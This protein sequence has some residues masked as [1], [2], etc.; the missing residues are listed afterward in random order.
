[1][2]F[3]VSTVT[4]STYGGKT[5]EILYTLNAKWVI[6][7]PSDKVTTM[8]LFKCHYYPAQGELDYFCGVLVQAMHDNM[9]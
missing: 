2:I 6:Q 5:G 4:S 3:L 8:T 7:S 9:G 1:M